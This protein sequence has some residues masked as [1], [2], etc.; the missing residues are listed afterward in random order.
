MPW[1]SDGASDGR[2]AGPSAGNGENTSGTAG[3]AEA[4]SA[5]VARLARWLEEHKRYP[6]MAQARG[7]EGT[8][9][10]RFTVNRGGRV[11]SHRLAPGTGHAVL[12]REIEAMI[13]RAQ[14]LPGI[15][16]ELSRQ[17]LEV[18]VPVSFRLR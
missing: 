2:G 5:Y 8:G 1:K 12:D 17:A 6:R 18:A 11:L 13:E 10:L 15:P 14:P 4:L 9:M 7:L 16:D 3:S